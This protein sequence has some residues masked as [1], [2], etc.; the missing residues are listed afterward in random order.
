M[1]VVD[2]NNEGFTGTDAH[3]VNGKLPGAD[4]HYDLVVVGAGPAG[5]A[6]A[7]EAAANGA[8][9]LLVDEHPVS[10]AQMG[11]D[12]P[13]WFGG[14][15]TG[16][17]AAKA[18]MIEQ[19]FM[20][21]PLFEQAF[22]AG[23]DVQLGVYAWGLWRNRA[24]LG[25]L[26]EAML[27]LAD[28]ERSWTVGFKAIV[29]A[30]GAR[31]LALAF[32][33][34][35]QPGVMGAQGLYALLTRYDA[36]AGRR[37]V[38]LGS[39]DLAL[40]TAQLALDKGLEVA[41]LVEVADAP[42]GDAAK[43]AALQAAGVPI[44]CASVIRGAPSGIDGVRAAVIGPVSGEGPGETLECDTICMAVGVVPAIELLDVAG[45][46]IV[47]DSA[48]GGH[49]P[50][51]LAGMALPDVFIAGD[52]AGLGHGRDAA[53]AQGRAAARQ[54]LGLDVATPELAANETDR[55][56]YRQAWLRALVAAT[57]DTVH[58]CQCEEV[59]RAD[60][61]GVQ[62]PQYLARPEKLGCRSLETLLHDGPPD[63]EQIKRLTRAC[64]GACQA[65][66][67]REQ[68]GMLMAMGANLPIEQAPRAGW[69]A[70]VRPLALKVLADWDEAEA[71]REGWDVWF[72]I[73][74]QWT[75][76]RDIG[77]E[78]EAMH[79]EALGGNMHL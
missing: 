65:R 64:M 49:V 1:S 11:N 58:V 39:G 52:C 33:G 51:A 12:V 55:L 19:V 73:P 48:R 21:E 15:M 50:Q 22:D 63:Q 40:D 38:V 54:A 24:N 29:L 42:Q 26:P 57:P 5:L 56:A 14:R 35:A 8:S 4:A 74:T 13:Y 6:A 9:V 53:A 34:W 7:L 47:T 36:F 27:G 66:R 76:Y 67:C 45:G 17:V 25:A 75:P 18:R 70:P 30:T 37:L 41:A 62:P 28:E 10:A 78:R 32:D 46:R 71:M 20:A 43:A 23:I 44:R 61:L 59:S 79:R 16:A 31:D 68:V 69:R 3:A 2:S 60:L 77:T 72:G